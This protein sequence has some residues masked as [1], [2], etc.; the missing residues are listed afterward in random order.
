MISNQWE[1]L[2]KDDSVQRPAWR[3]NGDEDGNK[4]RNG[5]NSNIRDGDK[6]GDGDDSNNGDGYDSIK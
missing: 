6:E 3:C 1:E 5:D 2:I 4:E